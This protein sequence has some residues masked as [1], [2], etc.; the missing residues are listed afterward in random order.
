MF[1]MVGVL[2]L[3]LERA[4]YEFVGAVTGEQALKIMRAQSIDLLTQDFMR[5]HQPDG[6][7]LIREMKADASISSI[8]VLGVSAG[9]I[10]FRRKR[11]KE[12]GLDFER[13]VDGYITKPFGP[14]ELIIA[15]EAIL[16]QYGKAI[17]ERAK[18]LRNPE[19]W[20]RYVFSLEEIRN[21]EAWRRKS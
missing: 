15:V 9:S 7:A 17:P 12:V 1:E 4:G 13:D 19:A 2:R 21:R 5:P 11:F 18:E 16:E 20:Q 8:P 3:V 14:A 6:R 10:D